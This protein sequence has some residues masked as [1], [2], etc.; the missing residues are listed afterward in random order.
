MVLY[1]ASVVSS[2]DSVAARILK[3]S[4]VADS[5][6]IVPAGTSVDIWLGLSTEQPVN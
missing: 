2:G 1:D 6:M 5:T 4:P 3:Q